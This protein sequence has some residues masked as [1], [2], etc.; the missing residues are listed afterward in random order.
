[1]ACPFCA[2]REPGLPMGTRWPQNLDARRAPDLCPRCEQRRDAVSF[3]TP[4]IGVAL[5]TARLRSEHRLFI[6]FRHER[7]RTATQRSS[8]RRTNPGPRLTAQRSSHRQ[9]NPGLRT[10]DATTFASTDGSPAIRGSVRHPIAS[11]RS[12]RASDRSSRPPSGIS[13]GC[14]D[15]VH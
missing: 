3:A 13:R 4:R 14:I 12:S 11:L 10:E 2:P 6:S 7:R 15:S 8:H 1:M 9:T 5:P